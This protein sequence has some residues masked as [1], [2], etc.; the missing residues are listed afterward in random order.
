MKPDELVRK[1][2][3]CDLSLEVGETDS[4]KVYLVVVR[5]AK[6]V[7]IQGTLNLKISRSRKVEEKSAK[8][9][10]KI[11]MQQTVDVDVEGK[12][13]KKTKQ[14]KVVFPYC[15]VN[16]IRREEMLTFET[17]FNNAVAELKKEVTAKV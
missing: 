2:T 3:A 9:Q 1:I 4:K 6:K 14:K 5:Q 7:L 16:F 10:L 8:N 12:D 15:V 13:G 17:E 11:A